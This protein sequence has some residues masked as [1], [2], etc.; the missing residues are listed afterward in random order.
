MAPRNSVSKHSLH[1]A[2][3]SP[4]SSS[5]SE[6]ESSDDEQHQLSDKIAD[7]FVDNEFEGR[8]VFIPEGS[9]DDILTPTTISDQ[10]LSCIDGEKDEAPCDFDELVKFIRF[11]AKKLFA[12][13]VC[14]KIKGH[15]LFQAMML[16]QKHGFTDDRL[17]VKPFPRKGKAKA[18]DHELGMLD[19]YIWDKETI[20]DFCERQWRF[21]A[22]VFEIATGSHS[23]P[24]DWHDFQHYHIL[25][26]IKKFNEGSANG[27]FGRVYKC[28]IHPKHMSPNPP[29]S[30]YHA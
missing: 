20:R 14:A 9:L 30:P 1:A 16:F 8:Q 18:R 3:P 15:D 10:L 21:L 25:P 27:S 17:P 7:T 4:E 12:I 29:V 11:R 19:K 5:A 23:P 28:Q 2:M 26:F 24:K 22:P 6:P 13:C